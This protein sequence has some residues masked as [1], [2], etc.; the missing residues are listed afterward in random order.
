MGLSIPNGLATIKVGVDTR[1]KLVQDILGV[2]TGSVGSRAGSGG[3]Q[4]TTVVPVRINLGIKLVTDIGRMRAMVGGASS[5]GRKA[6]SDAS[7]LVVSDAVVVSVLSAA[8]TVG[9]D[10]RVKLVGSV[11]VV[12]AVAEVSRCFLKADWRRGCRRTHGW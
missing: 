2:R 7:T 1:V 10:A 5:G 6:T 3:S 11:G 4:T 9:I 8:V 12:R